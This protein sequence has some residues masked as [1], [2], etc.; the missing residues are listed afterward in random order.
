MMRM[1]AASRNFLLLVAALAVP[2]AG[3]LAG[4]TASDQQRALYRMVQTD[5][6]RGN[7]GVVDALSADD[8]R[9][10]EAYVLWPDLR[11]TWLRANI[12]TAPRTTVDAF[13]TQYGTLRPARELRYR[14]ALAL[15]KRNQFEDFLELYQQ[16]Y[17]GQD[18]AKL[19]CLALQAEIKADAT[20]RVFGR[21]LALWSVGY[22]Q[23]SECDPVFAFIDKHGVLDRAAHEARYSLAMERREFSLARWLGKKISAEHVSA[24][25]DWTRARDNADAFLQE[26]K[27]ESDTP[28]LR[29]QLLYAV[30]RLTYGDPLKAR[31]RWQAINQRFHFSAAERS[32]TDRHIALWTARDNLPGAYTL[33]SKLPPAAIDEEVL[34]WRARISIRG[35]RWTQL[36]A[37]IAEMPIA[38]KSLEEWRYWQAV[39]IQQSDTQD[40]EQ[41]AAANAILELLS[42]ERSYYGFLAADAL[43]R[44]YAMADSGLI[45]DE[46]AIDALLTKPNLIRAREL[47]LVGQ[48]SRGRSEWD[49]VMRV[50]SDDEKRQAAILAHQWG[51][52]SRAIATAASLGEYDDLALRYP[53]P[54]LKQFEASANAAKITPT[55]SYGIARSESLFMPDVRSS[56]GAVGLMQ[57]MPAT[58]REVARSID[59]PY[60]GL[61]TLTTPDSNIRLGST[62]LGQMAERYGGNQMLATAAYNAGPHRV[63]RWL[64]EN[65]VLDARAWIENIPFNETRKYVKRVM[66]A[67]AIF[68]WRINGTVRRLS[69]ELPVVQSASR[70]ERLALLQ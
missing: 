19:D 53:L 63:D 7:W 70:I 2:G 1:L 20:E 27:Q 38:E 21:A 55:W 64:P 65:G 3:V 39:A 22:S 60:T 25:N 49:A 54:Y 18:V 61:N 6:E 10:L 14:Y 34:R 37:D 41:L 66:A 35:E 56:A 9:D 11:A 58:G 67:Q 5:V 13:L 23:V 57:L 51:W 52:H 29:Q 69:D 16:F 31:A 62:Y 46:L 28:T 8:R 15:A 12:N 33:L 17:Q 30:E 68:H 44:P 40:A 45:A 36:A 4:V 32:Q 42:L 26:Q 47:F 50:L 48:D 43:Q 24:A 59:L